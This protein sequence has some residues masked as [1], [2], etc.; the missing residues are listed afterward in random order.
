[1]LRGILLPHQVKSITLIGAH[2]A[3]ILIKTTFRLP[4]PIGLCLWPRFL[5]H[6]LLRAREHLIEAGRYAHFT[7]PRLGPRHT[8]LGLGKSLG[9]T[10]TLTLERERVLPF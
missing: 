8:V 9:D 3:P 7:R 4:E 5:A 10:R 2:D 1:M 6:E